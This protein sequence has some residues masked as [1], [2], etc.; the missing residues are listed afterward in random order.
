M[1]SWKKVPGMTQTFPVP[2][3]CLNVQR[4]KLFKSD[5]SCSLRERLLVPRNCVHRV[6]S[7]DERLLAPE[8]KLK[9]EKE[10]SARQF[11][12]PVSNPREMAY[13]SS[14]VNTYTLLPCHPVACLTRWGKK[15]TIKICENA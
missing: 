2:V 12:S 13:V 14:R 6:P 4:Q 5:E 1:R 15:E 11:F 10:T 3:V 9:W 8:V 7:R